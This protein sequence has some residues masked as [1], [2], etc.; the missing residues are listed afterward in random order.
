MRNKTI[1]IVKR[2]DAENEDI[3]FWLKKSPSERIEALQILREQHIYYFHKQKEY[4]ESR[5]GLRRF[6]SVSQRI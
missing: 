2:R 1:K 5:K 6:Y 4:R 3:K